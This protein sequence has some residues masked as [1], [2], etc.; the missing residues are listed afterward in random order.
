MQKI[1]NIIFDLDGTLWDSRKQIVKAW[2]S[3]LDGKLN[4]K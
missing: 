1:N 3:I 4:I 2:K